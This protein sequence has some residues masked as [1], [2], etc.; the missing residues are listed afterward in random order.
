[1]NVMWVALGGAIGAAARYGVNVWTPR[2]FGNDFPWSTFLV[3]VIGCLVMGVVAAL[4]VT[5]LAMP[6]SL[7]LFLTTG[8]LGGF[9]TFS[10]FALDFVVLFERK[11]P[12]LAGSYV[13]A[14]VLCS[15]LGVLSGFWFVRTLTA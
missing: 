8:I 2:L 4:A 14:S 7:K 11:S 12:M 9:T 13:L 6:D 1:M 15:L 3:N 10:A 5:K